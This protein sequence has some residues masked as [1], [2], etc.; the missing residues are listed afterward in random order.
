MKPGLVFVVI[1][2]VA[3]LPGTRYAA[4]QQS[5]SENS[6]NTSSDH[7]RD[8]EHA[9]P[10]RKRNRQT[11]GETSTGAPDHPRTSEKNPA[12]SPARVPAATRP[13]QPSRN[14]QHSRSGGA[15]NLHQP[16]LNRSGAV[17]KE[18][19]LHNQNET[20][21]RTLPIRPPGTARTNATSLSNVRQRGPNPAVIGGPAS[22]DTR[23]SGAISGNR[24]GRRPGRN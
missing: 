8:T 16:G 23:N 2:W 6:A 24:M 4:S 10:A 18:G 19:L 12:R 14:E 9:A 1:A 3:L 13:K 15:I 11:D 5:S 21:H 22:S 20:P 7:A 17:T